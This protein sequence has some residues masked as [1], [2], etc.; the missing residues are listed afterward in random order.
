MGLANGSFVSN[1]LLVS[2]SLSGIGVLLSSEF[3]L[4]DQLLLFILFVFL[5]VDCLDQDSLVFELVTLGGQVEVVVTM[6]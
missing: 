5:L 4:L 6:Q 3:C 2:L 1:E